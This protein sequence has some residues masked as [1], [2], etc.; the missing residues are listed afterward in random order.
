ML[1]GPFGGQ[2]AESGHAHA[3]WQTSF[4]GR[5]DEVGC[6]ESERDCHVDFARAAALACC[7]CLDVRIGSC[8][9]LV[10][11]A[12]PPCNRGDEKR[13]VLGTDGADLVRGRSFGH[14]NLPA[15]LGWRL[16]PWH[17]DPFNTS[18]SLCCTTLCIGQ[19]DDQLVRLDLDA[20]NVIADEDCVFAIGVFAEMIADRLCDERLDLVCRHAAD[21]SGLFHLGPA[22]GL[23]RCNSDT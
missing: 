20:D 10:E 5:P 14:Q 2:F 13:A 6:K 8:N 22:R 1:A 9:K 18:L 3:M 19:F 7:N 17:L 16:A 11:P 15:S 4:D 21:S 12:A 23:R